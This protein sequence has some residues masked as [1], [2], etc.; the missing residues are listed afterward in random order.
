MN[1]TQQFS[2]L[3]IF[4]ISQSI[5]ASNLHKDG[6]KLYKSHC[7]SCHGATGGMDM[8]KRIAPPIAGVRLH[9]M[10]PFPDKKS[11]INA[12]VNWTQKQDPDRSLMPPAIRKFK[13][14]PPVSVSR[15][16]AEKIAAYIYDGDI[17]ILDGFKEHV[18]QMH[19]KQ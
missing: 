11:F 14:M 2:A 15:K 16:Q 6:E 9:Y 1:I 8:S 18:E 7:S 4:L 17:E 19:G 3:V 12:I 5:L 13:I 10:A